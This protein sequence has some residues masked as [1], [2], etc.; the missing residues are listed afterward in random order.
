MKFFLRFAVLAVMC[1][2]IL[3]GCAPSG[4][5]PSLGEHHDLEGALTK[6]GVCVS[7]YDDGSEESAAKLASLGVSWYYNWGSEDPKLDIGAEYVPMIWGAGGVNEK[8]LSRIEEGV[9]AG[10][11]KHL[12]TFNE[13]DKDDAGVS[14]GVSVELALELWPRLEA[15]GVPLSSPS[16][17]AYRAGGWLDRFMEGAMERGYRVDFITLHCYQDFSEPKAPEEL[18][19]QLLEVYEKYSLPIWVTEFAAID[20]TMWG[21]GAGKRECTEEAA[22]RYAKETTDV[23]EELGFV[24]RYAW[25]IDNTGT[26]GETRG[27]EAQ[28]T[29]LFEDDDSLSATGKIYGE[30]G[31]RYPLSVTSEA[32]PA[33]HA[34][35]GYEFLLSA[36]GGRGGYE[37]GPS[38][39]EPLPPWLELRADGTLSGTPAEAGAFPV[40]VVCRD[41]DGQ[42]AYRRYTLYVS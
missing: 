3:G 9:K 6:K 30:V 39:E 18:R 25:W 37:F 15:L 14:S 36:G 10:T 22:L 20:I 31:S 7:R 4:D 26:A 17:A 42:I 19:E 33:G 29:F 8:T 27:R 2:A 28:F 1:L 12:L 41:E 11:V 13:P 21:G 5:I 34:G 16:P 35:E 40:C 32:L 23:L 38:D 24:E